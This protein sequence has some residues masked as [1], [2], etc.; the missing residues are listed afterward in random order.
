MNEQFAG[1]PVLVALLS[2]IVDGRRRRERPVGPLARFLEAA[3]LG[4]RERLRLTGVARRTIVSTPASSLR[5]RPGG[6]EAITP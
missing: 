4:R 2:R 6:V 1:V 3:R 5:H